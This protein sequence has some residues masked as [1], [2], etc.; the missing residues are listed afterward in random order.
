MDLSNLVSEAE[1]TMNVNDEK[2]Q[3]KLF[4]E[5]PSQLFSTLE[6][7]KNDTTAQGPERNYSVEAPEVDQACIAPQASITPLRTGMP[8]LTC[9]SESA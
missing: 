7:V 5:T 3:L 8:S 4:E 1:H 6:L 9:V 2:E